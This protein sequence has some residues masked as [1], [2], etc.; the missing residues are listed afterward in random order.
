MNEE[1]DKRLRGTGSVYQ[2]K[3]SRVWWVKYHRGKVYRESSKATTEL[4]AL[5]FLQMRLGEISTGNF[6]GPAV[7]PTRSDTSGSVNR[8]IMNRF[9]SVREWRNWQTR[10][11]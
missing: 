10:K 8:S 2:P 1:K 6:F 9:T 4:K 3:Q 7:G 11:T 5:K